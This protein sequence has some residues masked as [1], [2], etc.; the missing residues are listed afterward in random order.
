MEFITGRKERIQHIGKRVV[1]DLRM[2]MSGQIACM[3][4]FQH[5]KMVLLVSLL[6]SS[7]IPPSCFSLP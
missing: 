6:I 4:I 2:V 1:E 7:L 3:S 5:A